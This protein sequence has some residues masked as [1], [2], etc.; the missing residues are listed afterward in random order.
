MSPGQQAAEMAVSLLIFDQ[1]NSPAGGFFIRDL[2]ADNRPQPFPLTSGQKRPE[3][4]E[5]IRIGERKL[6]I[7]EEPGMMAECFDAGSS[8]HQ[9]IGGSDG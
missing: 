1:A 5:I 6:L 9:G 8:P 4:V 2:R 3:T 7:S